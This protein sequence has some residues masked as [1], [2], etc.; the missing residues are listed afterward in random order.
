MIANVSYPKIKVSLLVLDGMRV[1]VKVDKVG[2]A[3]A[4]L[5][6]GRNPKTVR[7]I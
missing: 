6:A 7:E 5:D 2:E 4:V 1:K 3:E